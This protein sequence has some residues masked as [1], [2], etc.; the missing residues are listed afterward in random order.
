MCQFS[1]CFFIIYAAVMWQWAVI[2]L[3]AYGNITAFIL[4]SRDAS[5]TTQPLELLNEVGFEKMKNRTA[6]SRGLEFNENNNASYDK[7]EVQQFDVTDNGNQELAQTIDNQELA[8]QTKFD[9][10]EG[11]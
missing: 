11:N 4:T 1:L 8:S 10:S 6:S 7:G 9:G 5:Y 2:F 3:G